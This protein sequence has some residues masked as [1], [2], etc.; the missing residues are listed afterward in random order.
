M[1]HTN[2]A[3]FMNRVYMWMCSGLVTTAVTAYLVSITPGLFNAIFS[4]NSWI[5]YGLILLELG[6]VVYLSA[7][8]SKM[9][10]STAGT[11][12]FLYSV[13]NGVTMASIFAIFLAT[14]IGLTFAIT[15]GMFGVMSLYGYT[16]KTD[17]TTVGNIAFMALIG[18]ILA[19]VVNLF[20]NNAMLD[21]VIS[22]IGVIVFVALTAYDTQKIKA[23]SV[24]VG[25]NEEA[26]QKASIIGALNLYLDFVNLFLFLLRIF[27][28]RD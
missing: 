20:L 7:M 15:A 3:Q 5:F 21:W 10:A 23:F 2:T 16:T 19:S 26:G 28:K 25:E 17:I 18:I 11:V 14:S 8:I 22:Y 12:F 6:M 24:G 1:Q 27:G 9:K 4:G 13:L